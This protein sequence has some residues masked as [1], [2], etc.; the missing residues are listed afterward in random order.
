LVFVNNYDSQISFQ[1]IDSSI[2]S[3]PHAYYEGDNVIYE[4]GKDS[5]FVIK[6]AQRN[7]DSNWIHTS[8]SDSGYNLNPRY[9]TFTALSYQKF[10]DGIWKGVVENWISDNKTYNITKPFYFI[11]PLITK[12]A[13]QPFRDFF[14][15]YES[16]STQENSEI[17]MEYVPD[18]NLPKINISNSMADDLNPYAIWMSDS[19]GI[20]WEQW[21]NNASQIWCAKAKSDFFVGIHDKEHS[22]IKEFYLEQNYPNPFNPNTKIS[23]N[24]M[25]PSK[26]TLKI[27]N[28]LGE[29]IKTL[30]SGTL[31]S[32]LHTVEWDGTNN[33][34]Q[35]ASSGVY[36]YVLESGDFRLSKKMV[37]IK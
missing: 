7:Y 15:V 12:L 10:D 24:I 26:I 37:I 4:Q 11:F 35:S 36:I 27:F 18:V 20:F 8:H 32:G 9:G 17:I 19:I 28:L 14:V 33:R 3:N 2:C 31:D 5:S 22:R 13:N 30:F 25:K 29:E 34:F 21:E 16:D 6:N 23:F 1:I